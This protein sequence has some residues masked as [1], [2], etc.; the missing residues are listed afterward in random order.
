MM[1]MKQMLNLVVLLLLLLLLLPS[2]WLML[3]FEVQEVL[4]L[5]KRL[6]PFLE[7]PFQLHQSNRVKEGQQ[8]LPK[9]EPRCYKRVYQKRVSWRPIPKM[10]MVFLMMSKEEAYWKLNVFRTNNR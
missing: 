5:Q 10:M 3:A 8:Q 6:V 7:P 1:K 2:Y 4:Q 9:I